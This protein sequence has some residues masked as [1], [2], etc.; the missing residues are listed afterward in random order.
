VADCIRLAGFAGQ[1]W[2]AA[3][4]LGP[5]VQPP[6]WG[7]ILGLLASRAALA[8]ETW[9]MTCLD[10]DQASTAQGQHSGLNTHG[11]VTG[12]ACWPTAALLLGPARSRG[13]SRL[14]AAR[15]SSAVLGL[16]CMGLLGIG[17]RLP[18]ST[19]AAEAIGFWGKP[20][21]WLPSSVAHAPLWRS[22]VTGRRPS[23]F[24]GHGWCPLAVSDRHGT[25]GQRSNTSLG[26]SI[27]FT[28]SPGWVRRGPY[29]KA[30]PWSGSAR[31]QRRTWLPWFTP[32]TGRS[33]GRRCERAVGAHCLLGV[34]GPG[35][36][37]V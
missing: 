19:A 8:W 9:P 2:R 24:L 18:G 10:A 1:C 6:R 7:Q 25:E 17:L 36:L 4:G 20:S 16:S 27:C 33:S 37:Y 31:P 35:R 21:C 3:V 28:I 26:C 32:D 11:A 23:P 5:R 15:S 29:G 14:V 13:A 34:I 12:W 22:P 30:H